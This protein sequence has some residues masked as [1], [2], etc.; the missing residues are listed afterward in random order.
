LHLLLYAT[1]DGRKSR[2]RAE[3]KPDL[4]TLYVIIYWLLRLNSLTWPRAKRLTPTGPGEGIKSFAAPGTAKPVP[5]VA[6]LP[7]EAY[8]AHRNKLLHLLGSLDLQPCCHGVLE[9]SQENYGQPYDTL[10]WS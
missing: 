9:M 3:R 7:K 8:A 1:V 4:D 5:G 6:E 10:G 2:S